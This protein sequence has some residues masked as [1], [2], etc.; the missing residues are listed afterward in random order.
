LNVYVA[1]TDNQRI[2]ALISTRFLRAFERTVPTPGS[3]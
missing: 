3:S 2:R 1:D